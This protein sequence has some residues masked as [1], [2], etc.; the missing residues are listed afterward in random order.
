MTPASTDEGRPVPR[1]IGVAALLAALAANELTL[2][3]AVVP[4][5]EIGSAVLRGAILVFD[6]LAVGFGVWVLVRRPRSRI[7]WRELVLAA[8]A[9]VF[10]WIAAYTVVDTQA[11]GLLRG[12]GIPYF[13]LRAR[14]RADPDL[15][16]VPRRTGH[17][18]E[19]RLRGDLF[20][21]DDDM[22][23]AGVDY[24]A[25]YTELGFRANSSEP[26]YEVVVLGDSFVEF[27]E[28]DSTTV[29]E[30]LTSATGLSTYNLGRAW[31]GPHQYA[32]LLRRHGPELEPDFAVVFFFEGNDAEDAREHEAWR[33]GGS[34]H[35]FSRAQGPLWE[36]FGTATFDLISFLQWETAR[37]L[38]FRQELADLLGHEE[39]LVARNTGRVEVEGD[40]VRM[41]F[42]YW[43]VGGDESAD[44]ILDTPRW[45]AARRA[46]E[47]FRETASANGITPIAVFL[48]TKAT[49]YADRL[50]EPPGRFRARDL[51]VT[52]RSSTRAHALEALAE[53]VAIPFLDVTPYFREAAADRPLLYYR[54]DTHWAPRGRRV[55]AEAVGAFLRE[56][57]PE[58][59][60]EATGV[61]LDSGDRT[62][63]QGGRTKR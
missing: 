56:R 5:G 4:D 40:S 44:E 2:E 45:R 20:H 6:L 38:G 42:G 34:Y 26:P 55:A 10:A 60:E 29:S 25:S 33:D 27:G 41:K 16:M 36:R 1:W 59:V 31:Y 3:A 37:H 52:G 46:L 43:P 49:T 48:P 15:V 61:D 35:H 19:F 39:P 32:E 11:P 63:T 14:Y 17:E 57:W 24:R 23:P 18:E 47:R 8:V 22:P 53:D 12:T 9:A 28:S 50:L 30:M 21:P 54:Q 58:E 62:G 51:A 13:E 7:P